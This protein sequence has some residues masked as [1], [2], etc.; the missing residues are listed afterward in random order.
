[1]IVSDTLSRLL[2]DKL[3]A[4]EPD[5]GKF[6]GLFVIAVLTTPLINFSKDYFA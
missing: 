6:D 4:R 2:I 1:M 3:G 5:F